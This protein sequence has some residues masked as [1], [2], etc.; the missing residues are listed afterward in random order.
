MLV[1]VMAGVED[2]PGVVMVDGLPVTWPQAMNLVEK[3]NAAGG[4]ADRR[5][6]AGRTRRRDAQTRSARTALNDTPSAPGHPL[7]FMV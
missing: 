1:D 5:P 6:A 7:M 2:I 3:F 4:P